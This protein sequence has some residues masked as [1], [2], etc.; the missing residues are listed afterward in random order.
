VA[1]N[2]NKRSN[3]SRLSNRGLTVDIFVYNWLLIALLTITL[4]IITINAIS[5]CILEQDVWSSNH[6]FIEQIVAY[7]DTLELNYTLINTHHVDNT[8][9]RR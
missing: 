2:S 1:E 6:G 7:F 9:D 8:I 5:L 4:I 3:P